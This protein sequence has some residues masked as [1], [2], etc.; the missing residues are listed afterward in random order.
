[1]ATRFMHNSAPAA[2]SHFDKS[3]TLSWA[4]K[5]NPHLLNLK[6]AERTAATTRLQPQPQHRAQRKEKDEMRTFYTKEW[7]VEAEG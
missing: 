7:Q 3:A 4:A 2:F 5:T 6:L 1:M